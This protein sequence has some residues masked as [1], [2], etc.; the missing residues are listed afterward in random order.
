MSG[1]AGRRYLITGGASLIGSHLT[2]ALLDAGVAEVVLYDNLSLGSAGLVEALTRDP[3]VRVVRGDVLRLPSLME[4][5]TGV[6]GVFALAAYLT[7]PLSADPALGVEVNVMGALNV[8]D[9]ARLLGGRKVVF[10]SSI[11]VYGSEI[12]EEVTEET[13]FR[14]SDVSPA[15]AS[16]AASKLLGESLGRLYVQKHG[17]EVCAVRFSTVY[18]ENQH[19]RGVNALYILEA[20]QAVRAGRPPTVRGTGAEAHDYLHAADAARGCLSA[21]EHGAPGEA[22]NLTSGRSTS[23]NEIVAMVLEEY[24]SDLRPEFVADNRTAR[25]TEHERLRIPSA[26]ARNALGWEAKISVREGIGRLRRWLDR[27]SAAQ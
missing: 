26:K 11:A 6:D 16:Y 9:A 17:V 27:V 18:G 21:M 4:A 8:L 25:S 13:P 2:Q 5:M 10:A 7:L 19:E 15:F 12:H 1:I 14:S 3:R 20:M 24:G 23:V 22:F